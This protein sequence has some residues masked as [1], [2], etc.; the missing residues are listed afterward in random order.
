MY[1]Y[2]IQL[3]ISLYMSSYCLHIIE[4][5]RGYIRNGTSQKKV[6]SYLTSQQIFTKTK[7]Q[8][9]PF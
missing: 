3:Y 8:L 5:T 7:E 9:I 4:T 1:G 2:K 6:F